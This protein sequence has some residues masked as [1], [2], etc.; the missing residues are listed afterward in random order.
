VYPPELI[1]LTWYAVAKIEAPVR[2]RLIV[3]LQAYQRGAPCPFLVDDVCSVH[4]LRPMACRQ[5]NVFDRV[6]TEGEDAYYTRRADVLTPIKAYADSAFEQLLP[7][8]GVADAAQRRA[9]I[10]SGAVH[11]SVRVLQEIDWAKVAARMQEFDD[12]RAVT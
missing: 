3:Q 4:P 7:L 5:F 6:C 10:E 11:Q 12:R 8:M 2:T 9:L 1:G